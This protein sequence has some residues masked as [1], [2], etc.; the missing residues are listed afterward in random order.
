MKRIGK[1]AIVLA[2]AAC[3]A[4]TAHARCVRDV[5]PSGSVGVRCS[6]GVRGELSAED[7]MT[8]TAASSTYRSPDRSRGTSIDYGG[9]KVTPS[10]SA[11]SATDPQV[12]QLTGAL[13]RGRN[14]SAP[15]R[16]LY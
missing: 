12:D 10:T 6:S 9:P 1:V 5:S 13:S 11:P 8:G 2:L 14:G 4:Q 16:R 7:V 15:E 3:A